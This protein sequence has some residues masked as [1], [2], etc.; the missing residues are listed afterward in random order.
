M[1]HFAWAAI[2][3]TALIAASA[4]VYAEDAVKC[5]TL[6]EL[7]DDKAQSV[8]FRLANTCKASFECSLSW[9]VTCDGGSKT[10]NASATLTEGTSTTITASAAFCK[11]DWEVREPSWTCNA[12]H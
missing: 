5:M 7:V 12:R 1:A 4:H 10:G 6:S 9:R 8:D 11:G 2:G 3:A